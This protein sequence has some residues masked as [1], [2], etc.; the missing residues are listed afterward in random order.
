MSL[1]GQRAVILKKLQN[2]SYVYT[3]TLA[4]KFP[5]YNARIYE[6]R[7]QGHTIHSIMMNRKNAFVLVG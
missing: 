1:E 3:T 7:N 4:A 2:Q 5:Q 6:L